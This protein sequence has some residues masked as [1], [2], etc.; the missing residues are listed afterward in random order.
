MAEEKEPLDNS[1][2]GKSKRKL[3]RLQNEL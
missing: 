1:R 2:L 3:A